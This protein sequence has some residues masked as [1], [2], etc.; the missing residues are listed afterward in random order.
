MYNHTKV[1]PEYLFINY[2]TDNANKAPASL[3]ISATCSFYN[4]IK[5]AHVL[6]SDVS[7]FLVVQKF[8]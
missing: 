4:E 3:L 1:H 2:E 8:T 5:P 7:L 6:T